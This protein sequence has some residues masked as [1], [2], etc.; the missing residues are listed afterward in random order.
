M[1]SGVPERAVAARSAGVAR[2]R[3]RGS[4]APCWRRAPYADRVV[5]RARRLGGWRRPAEMREL[6][7][8]RIVQDSRRLCAHRAI[9]GRRERA[10]GI[11]AAS[12]GNHAQGVALASS[13]L[14]ATST[15]FMPEGAPLPKV[16]ATRKYGADVRFF[17][18]TLDE[19]LARGNLVRG[20]HRRGLDS[21]VRSPRH[22]RRPGDDR[23]GD[24][25]AV[26]RC[27]DH[28]GQHRRWRVAVWRRRRR[29][30]PTARHQGRR[31]AG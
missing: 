7:T 6:A 15:V 4:D 23:A 22:R 19:A 25:R 29:Q 20:R 16:E 12:A 13:L 14:G 31:G 28:R 5:A 1:T 2:G 30:S 11:V 18:H 26:S 21:P 9:D 3:A 8:R 27:A 10:R 24:P 17:G